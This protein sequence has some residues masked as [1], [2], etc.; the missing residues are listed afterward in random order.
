[1]NCTYDGKFEGN[2]LVF[3]RTGSG[4]TAFVQNLAK[5]NMFGKLK[6]I[7]C[8]SKI[9]LSKEREDQMRNCFVDEHAD[10]KYVETID[11]F[12]DLVEHIQKKKKKKNCN[13]NCLG[14]SIEFDCIFVLGNV[15]GL[16]DRSDTFANFLTV[17]RKSGLT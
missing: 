15:S 7:I 9:L 8:S 17:S 12:E 13:E 16:A 5:N 11:E 3:G 10:F 6:E 4:K 14:E 1:M 2:I